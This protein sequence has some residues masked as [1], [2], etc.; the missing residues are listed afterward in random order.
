M[1][2]HSWEKVDGGPPEVQWWI[3][4]RCGASARSRAGEE[5]TDVDLLYTGTALDCDEHLVEAVHLN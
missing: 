5:L 4:N 3:C 2:T 1:R